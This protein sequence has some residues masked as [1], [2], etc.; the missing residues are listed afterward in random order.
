MMNAKL[1]TALSIIT[2]PWR[3]PWRAWS[4]RR[5][6]ATTGKSFK[7]LSPRAWRPPGST[8]RLRPSCR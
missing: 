2:G 3:M 4:P 6:L 7:S 5:K 8:E 1:G